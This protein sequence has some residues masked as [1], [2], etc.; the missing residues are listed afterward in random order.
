VPAA[1]LRE[2]PALPMTPT[3]TIAMRWLTLAAVL[4]L[5]CSWS[6][7]SPDPPPRKAASA[8]T[9]TT[10][11]PTEPV[12]PRPEAAAALGEA[13]AG[14]YQQARAAIAG[15]TGS[16]RYLGEGFGN[17]MELAVTFAE[18]AAGFD[19]FEYSLNC[20]GAE[21][22]G[23][24]KM[25]RAFPPAEVAKAAALAPQLGITA[26]FQ[27][28]V[29]GKA[30]PGWAKPRVAKT[31]DGRCGEQI[32]STATGSINLAAGLAIDSNEVLACLRALCTQ[33]QTGLAPPVVAVQLRGLISGKGTAASERRSEMSLVIE[34]PSDMRHIFWD[35]FMRR[36]GHR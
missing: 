25:V 20:A 24:C 21:P 10:V 22:P 13:L 1:P 2:Y 35:T 28:R 36:V 5:S 3:V 6:G 27:L 15:T 7:C 4:G 23:I 12:D 9:A 16:A 26:P 31:Y 30:D 32:C 11:I 8:P 29:T 17:L 18:D 34:L 19:D 14:V 33:A